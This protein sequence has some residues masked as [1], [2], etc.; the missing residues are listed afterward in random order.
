[1]RLLKNGLCL[2]GIGDRANSYF[3]NIKGHEK[4]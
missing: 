2:F 1:M 3:F 4:L